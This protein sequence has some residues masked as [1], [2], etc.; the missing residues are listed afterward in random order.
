MGYKD[1]NG[2][3]VKVAM[4]AIANIAILIAHT[5]RGCILTTPDALRAKRS[6]NR[7]FV[8]TH[9]KLVDSKRLAYDF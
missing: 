2:N 7:D 6:V 9:L 5:I 3:I 8:F 4:T 1:N